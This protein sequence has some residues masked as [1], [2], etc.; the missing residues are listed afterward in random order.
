MKICR[1][2]LRIATNAPAWL[3]CDTCH[4]D[5]PH[6]DDCPGLGTI[7]CADQCMNGA[8]PLTAALNALYCLPAA[9]RTR[10]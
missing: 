7:G 4:A 8:D 1:H 9:E 10:P 3:A 5:F 6:R 2:V